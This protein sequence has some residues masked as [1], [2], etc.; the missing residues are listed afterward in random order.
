MLSHEPYVPDTRQYAKCIEVSKRIRWDIENDVI[1]G[2][3]YEADKK[4]LPDGLSKVNDINFLTENEKRFLSQVQGRTYANIFGLV[5]RF[6]CAKVIEV[7]GDYVLGDQTALQALVGFSEEELKHQEMFRRLEG[8]AAETMPAGYEFLPQPNEVAK[9][10]LG[11]STWAVLGLTLHIELFTQ[12]HYRDSIEHQAGLSGLWKDV[13]LYHW[14]EESQ[15]AIMDEMEWI[16]ENYRISDEERDQAVN[17]LID[18]VVAVDSIL[19]VQSEHD[20]N[21]FVANCDRVFSSD[22]VRVIKETIL[23]A[24]RWQYI[25]SGVEGPRFFKVLSRFINEDQAQRI[26]AALE[27]LK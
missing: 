20:T 26:G 13:F 19:Q 2:R 27:T 15:H 10:V 1:R 3:H 8:I 4:F 17:D 11:K 7:S 24:Y 9:A 14:K 22:E 5:E 23:K 18:L 25:F 6:I 16:R 12:Q 21:Y